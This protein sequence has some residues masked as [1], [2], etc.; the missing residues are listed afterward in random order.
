MLDNEALCAGP[1][2][3]P[4]EYKGATVSRAVCLD[5][6]AGAHIVDEKSWRYDSTTLS[7]ANC[8]LEAVGQEVPVDSQ[9]AVFL[10]GLKPKIRSG[11]LV[12][13]T[14]DCASLGELVN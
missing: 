14:P 8:I 12:D 4:T 3:G 6:G 1:Q 10:P 5:S 7:P 9:A 2:L 13:G 11:V